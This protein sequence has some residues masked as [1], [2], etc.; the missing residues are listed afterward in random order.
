MKRLLLGFAA[1]CLLLGVPAQA[2]YHYYTYY[3]TNLGFPIPQKFDLTRLT[4]NTVSLLVTDSG[5]ATFYPNDSFGSVLGEI[6]E[7]V[8]AW[9]SAPASLLRINFGGLE[10]PNQTAN[11]PG[12][13][14][15][16][17]NLAPGI[18]GMGG[19]Q[20]S[21]VPNIQGSAY[22]TFVPITQSVVILTN[23]TAQLPGPSYLEG[24][25]TTAVHEI[26]HALGLQHTWTAAAM[27]QG[28][29]RNTSRARPIDADDI[30]G[31]SVLYGAPNWAANYGTV[32]GQVTYPDGSP[33]A[34]ASVVA[35]PANGPAV[36]ALTNPDGTYTIQGLPPNT[37][38]LYVHPLPP[39]AIAGAGEGLLQP[40]DQTGRT[41]AMSGSFYTL[42]YPG[43]ND[44]NQAQTLPISAGTNLQ[45]RNFTVQPRTGVP[46]YDLVTYSYLDPNARTYP[47]SPAQGTNYLFVTPAFV[48]ATQNQALVVMQANAG[49]TV[50]PSSV[51]MLGVGPAYYNQLFSNN[52]Y[53]AIYFSGIAGQ[54]TGPRHL[55]FQFG[56]DIYVLPDAVNLVQ[57]GPPQVTSVSANGDGTVTVTGTG[58]GADT[59]VFFDGLQAPAVLNNGSLI[60]TPP[61]GNGGQVSAVTVF[62][63]DG[64]NSI[65]GVL[66]GM[67]P[68]QFNFPASPA[69]Q[70]LTVTPASL[71]AGSTGM[72]DITANNG[73][74]AD[75]QV[76]LGFGTHDVIVNKVYR[77]SSNRLVAN[78][79]VASGA[80]PGT[81]EI[82]ILS[83][84]Q[85][86]N[87]GTWNTQGSATNTPQVLALVNGGSP[88]ATAL[89][90]GGYAVIYGTNLATGLAGTQV[91]VNG[92]AA[93]VAFAG[94]TQ[95]N[96]VVPVGLATGGAA[97][98]LNSS[99]G[100]TSIAAQI[101]APAPQIQSVAGPNGTVDATH[102]ANPG[103]LLTVTVSGLDASVANNLL[104]MQIA[105]AG[106]AMSP[107]QVT[108]GAGGTA[109]VQFALAQSFGGSQV[110]LTIAVD[111]SAN[112]PY[113]I[114][115]R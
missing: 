58:F 64:Q 54:S 93:A 50:Q 72:V 30:A 81:S 77:V 36:S 111:G 10:A 57:N 46:A 99:R 60:A 88:S 84:F 16:F 85:V 92:V 45:A 21:S 34:L 74:F 114:A 73:D 23:N 55:V 33:V 101:A 35:I 4:G 91:S 78:V 106:I 49:S 66:Q 20:I 76:T 51:N 7:A 69:P 97:V 113:T 38:L 17:Q 110:P 56:N 98:T 2:Y 62:N 32:S 104:R 63:S 70:V 82:S 24:F 27:S 79:T 11:T 105:V 48:D 22:G 65:F 75:G 90:P 9:N 96:F 19:P 43:T 103:D 112:A 95:V 94:P 29:I 18:V 68:P 53:D 71:P 102:F 15:V 31:L 59:R 28:V 1:V 80:A 47:A 25:F 108:P 100:S 8:A 39:D 87:G 14:V 52:Q 41:L 107:L 86:V 89:N 40:T 5:P 44:P 61:A 12:I 37:Y 67:N 83:G 13:R 109:Q 3:R 42:F 26:G 115:A 6:K